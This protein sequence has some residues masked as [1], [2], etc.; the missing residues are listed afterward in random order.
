MW[1]RKCID[2]AFKLMETEHLVKL[3]GLYEWILSEKDGGNYYSDCKNV[4]HFLAAA[5]I[6]ISPSRHKEP[7]FPEQELP[8]VEVAFQTSSNLHVGLNIPLQP[9]KGLFHLNKCP[10]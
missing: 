3:L 1:E 4:G 6:A 2:L 7:H 10:E 9:S 5:P 8:R